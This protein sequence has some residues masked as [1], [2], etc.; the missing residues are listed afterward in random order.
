MDKVIYTAIFGPYDDLKEPTVITPGWQY[1]CYTD[2]PLQSK[3]WDIKRQ[4]NQPPIS[5]QR[6]ARWFKLNFHECVLSPISI[7]I[8][9]SFT[10]NT[11]LNKWCEKHFLKPFSCAK[12]PIRDCVFQEA[13]TCIKN[14]RGNEI[15]IRKQAESYLG[16][17]PKHNGIITS[18]IL[19]RKR[20]QEVIALCEKWWTELSQQSTRD[21]LAFAKVSMGHE[22]IIHTYDWDYRPGNNDEEFI[23]RT[24]IHRR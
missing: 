22:D 6:Q 20:T 9:G 17:V 24:H 18:G 21:Q 16:V 23:F 5:P 8:D 13:S 4:I 1:I 12:H 3:V 10:I 19:M 14:N 15:D 7:W 2:Q 11:D